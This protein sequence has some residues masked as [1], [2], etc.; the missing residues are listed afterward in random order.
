M[1]LELSEV[2]VG[3]EKD[4]L[5][6]LQV[7]DTVCLAFRH[8]DSNQVLCFVFYSYLFVRQKV[9]PPTGGEVQLVTSQKGSTSF[10]FRPFGIPF[11]SL[12]L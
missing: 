1:T 5:M 6:K 12:P 7:S 2:S 10:I 8:V 4:W 9:A 3:L 11:A